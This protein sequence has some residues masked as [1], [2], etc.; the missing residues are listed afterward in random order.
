MNFIDFLN[1]I[2]IFFEIIGFVLLLINFRNF[3]SNQRH[4]KATD[5]KLYDLIIKGL[6]ENN[7][8][9]AITRIL[10]KYDISTINN[11]AALRQSDYRRKIYDKFTKIPSSDVAMKCI[12][13]AYF[14][15]C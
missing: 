3:I 10:T 15:C 1:L 5:P 11:Y 4:Q 7:A 13:S 14:Q 9:L 6:K 12:E 2:G 8:D